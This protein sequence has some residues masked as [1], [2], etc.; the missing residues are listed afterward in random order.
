MKQDYFS[1]PTP[2]PDELR[3]M[4]HPQFRAWDF[5][6]ELKQTVRALFSHPFNTYGKWY[7]REVTDVRLRDMCQP[8]Y[9]LVRYYLEHPQQFDHEI[10]NIAPAALVVMWRKFTGD[11]MG[12]EKY[13]FE[14]YMPAKM[15]MMKINGMH[16]MLMFVREI[17]EG[18]MTIYDSPEYIKHRDGVG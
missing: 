14:Q 3:E 15:K 13:P 2:F 1:Y 8:A 12:Y 16:F 10:S 11:K 4:Y 7:A 6:D 17:E 18:R 9:H 5:S